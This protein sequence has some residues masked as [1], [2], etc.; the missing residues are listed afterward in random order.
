[1]PTFRVALRPAVQRQKDRRRLRSGRKRKRQVLQVEI[2]SR[3][4]S[5]AA[6]TQQFPAPAQNSLFS[7]RREQKV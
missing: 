7:V 3:Q 6:G 4:P 5:Q 1:M 2:E